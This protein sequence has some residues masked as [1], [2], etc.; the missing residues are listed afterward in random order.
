MG[1]VFTKVNDLLCESNKEELFITAFEGVLDLRTGEL[2]F[3]NAGHEKP[4]VY[5]KDEDIWEVYPTRAGFVLAGLEG[6]QY[7]SGTMN[8]KKGDRLF[9]YTDGI[10]EAVNPLNEQYGMDRLVRVL[11]RNKNTE[12]N[13]MITDIRTDVD[14]FADG[15]EQFDDITMLCMEFNE[16]K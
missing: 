5:H 8:L 13:R 12:L 9:L 4:I 15:A 14:E 7:R 10:P 11:Q 3:V 2:E 16:Y 1:E 6:I